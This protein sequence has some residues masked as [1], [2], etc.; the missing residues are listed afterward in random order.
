M[1]TDQVVTLRSEL[2]TLQT[3]N[4]TLSAEYEKVFDMERIQAAVGD[5]LSLIHI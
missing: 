3:E 2:T 1:L 5:T 4:A